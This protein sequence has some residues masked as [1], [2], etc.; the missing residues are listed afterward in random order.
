MEGGN[1]MKRELTLAVCGLALLVPLECPILLAQAERATPASQPSG[2]SI[3]ACDSLK[4]PAPGESSTDAA[5]RH[6]AWWL[7]LEK[8]EGAG[9]SFAERESIPVDPENRRPVA[10]AVP[11]FADSQSLPATRTDI[12]VRNSNPNSQPHTFTLSSGPW[13]KV[14]S[15]SQVR[16]ESHRVL[17]TLRLTRK[18]PQP[19]IP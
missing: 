9:G 6:K 4:K 1:E 10:G 17:A 16:R 11:G 3:Q 15:V 19:P 2:L 14:I 12:Y 5:K 13:S 8:E 18:T 7:C